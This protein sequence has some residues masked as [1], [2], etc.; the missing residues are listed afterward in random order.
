MIAAA[1]LSRRLTQSLRHRHLLDHP[2]YRR[3]EAGALGAGELGAYAAQ[4]RHFEAALPATL[5]RLLTRLPDGPAADLVR[6]NLVDEESHPQPHVAL[7]EMFAGAV[8]APWQPP[9]PATR[10]LLETYHRLSEAGGA[11]GLAAVVAYEIQAP[12]VAASKAAGLRRHY[13]LDATAT[14]F[15]D[16]HA[17][18]DRDH[19]EWAVEA[20]AALPA[21]PEVVLEAAGAAADAWWRFLDEREARV[22]VVAA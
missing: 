9:S 5:R 1:V 11:Q 21:P 8:A 15:W 2:F 14:A 13:A 4:Y 22:G 12:E 19:A 17:A 3:W 7:F 6:L 16:V 20:L 18:M 10:A